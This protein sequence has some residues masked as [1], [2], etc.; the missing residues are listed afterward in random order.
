[1]LPSFSEDVAF[2]ALSATVM[3]EYDGAPPPLATTTMDGEEEDPLAALLYGD[4]P[5]MGGA[6]V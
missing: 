6:L 2:K 3:F 4:D 1:M 5:T